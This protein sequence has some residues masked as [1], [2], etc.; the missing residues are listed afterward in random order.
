MSES[1]C[2]KLWDT[3]KVKLLGLRTEDITTPRENADSILASDTSNS[4]KV[5][6]QKN[7][8]GKGTIEVSNKYIQWSGFRLRVLI[9]TLGSVLTDDE[10]TIRTLYAHIKIACTGSV[11]VFQTPTRMGQ[12]RKWG[13]RSYHDFL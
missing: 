2:E 4:F 5:K 10:L 7:P 9:K 11:L 12:V 1:E 3:K 8:R 6:H 13:N